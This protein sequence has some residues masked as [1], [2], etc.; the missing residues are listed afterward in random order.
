[1]TNLIDINSEE[2]SLLNRYIGQGKL[3]ADLVFFGNEPGT[4][5][6]GVKD[7]LKHLR[8]DD[9]YEVG[10][11][12][13][14]KE[15]YAYP[16]TSDF[17]RFMARLC[18]GIKYKDDRWFSSLSNLGKVTLNEHIT[19]PLSIKPH[20]LVNLRPL[21]RPTQD[22]WEYSNIDKKDYIKKWNFTLKRHYSDSDKDERL[23]ILK[24]FFYSRTGLVIGIGEKENKKRF[25]ENIYPDI[26]F[27]TAELE[28]HKIYFS[29]ANKIIL[30][31]Y[32][33]NRNGIKIVGLKD[34]YEF[35]LSRNLCER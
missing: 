8:E 26:K 12:F 34:L 14:L 27:H 29:I 30:S 20:A 4:S 16:T 35:I 31:D 1:M 13:M 11:G 15:S 25:F 5:G 22:T 3:D 28:H 23:E 18:L 24:T 21:P 33:N 19:S 9:R 7:T 2:Y 32:F 6:C 17:A 10:K